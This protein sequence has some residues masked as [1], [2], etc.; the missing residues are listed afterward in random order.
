MI[1]SQKHSDTL[2]VDNDTVIRR[3]RHTSLSALV[4]SKRTGLED[5]VGLNAQ[6]ENIMK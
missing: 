5:K 1:L 3:A 2:L 6:K 4:Q